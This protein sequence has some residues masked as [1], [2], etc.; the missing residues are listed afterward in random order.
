MLD[1][2]LYFAVLLG[3]FLHEVDGKKLRKDARIV[4][5]IKLKFSNFVVLPL[6]LLSSLI[7]M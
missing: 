4:Y 3:G 2:G 1:F 6:L 5:N 7:I